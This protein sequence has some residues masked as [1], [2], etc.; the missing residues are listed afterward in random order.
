MANFFL[1]GFNERDKGAAMVAKLGMNS[2]FVQVNI[3]DADSLEAALKGEVCNSSFS[4]RPLNSWLIRIKITCQGV[5]GTFKSHACQFDLVPF[6]LM[7]N[8][9]CSLT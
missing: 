2:E 4:S 7:M 8:F 1:V 3:D 9:K 6:F 5:T